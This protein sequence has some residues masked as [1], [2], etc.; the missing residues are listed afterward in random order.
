MTARPKVAPVMI[1]NKAL[2]KREFLIF[3]VL[4]FETVA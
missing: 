3:I 2:R 4:L 1:D